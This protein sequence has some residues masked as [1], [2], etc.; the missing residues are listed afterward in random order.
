MATIIS[1]I[2][3]KGGVAKSTTAF[4]LASALWLCGK[5]VCVVDA[6]PQYELTTRMGF[7]LK[8]VDT[9]NEWLLSEGI[10]DIDP[11]IYCRYGD[12][13]D[14]SF[15]PSS[16]LIADIE[17]SFSK[18]RDR[19]TSP[20]FSLKN[21][22]DKLRDT[23]DYIF[24]D[25]P[26][27]PGFMNKLALIASDD[28]LVPVECAGE[29]IDGILKLENVIKSVTKKANPDLKMLG[30]LFTKYDD[31]TNIT[32]QIKEEIESDGHLF[33]TKIR[34][35]VRFKEAGMYYKNIFEYA[36]TGNGSEDYMALAE[37]LF[38]VQRPTDW[39]TRS[40][41]YWNKYIGSQEESE[42]IE[43]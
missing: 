23:F 43:C 39:Q 42:N 41:E 35:S 19:F 30:Y 25:C 14:F 11:P 7:F 10:E 13:M 28:I 38:K 36:P 22:L 37:E 33:K 4:N 8:D 9:L 15:I 6:D 34:K 24:I 1:V 26:P 29:S 17:L 3:F 5:K 20:F 2:N 12:L 21:C 32:R 16:S 40:T 31:R 18:Q 27:S